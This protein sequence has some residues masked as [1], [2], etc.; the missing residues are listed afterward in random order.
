MVLLGKGR[1]IPKH[2]YFVNF[3]R[4]SKK[5]FFKKFPLLD[6]KTHG[7]C[8][9]KYNSKLNNICSIYIIE[10]YEDIPLWIH[11]ITHAALCFLEDKSFS[12]KEFS[13]FSDQ[14]KEE[15][16]H[17][18]I[19]RLVERLTKVILQLLKTNE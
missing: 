15:Y 18:S 17:E 13:L 16:F 10:E 1:F 2:K 19:P 7:I 14:E 5:D 6:K 4:I 9:Y 11:E 3:Y 12:S 8:S